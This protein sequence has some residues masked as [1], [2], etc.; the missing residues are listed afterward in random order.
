MSQSRVLGCGLG[1]GLGC[2]LG[3]VLG[4]LGLGL[5]FRI[6]TVRNLGKSIMPFPCAYTPSITSLSFSSFVSRPCERRTVSS[7]E[8]VTL[9]LP[10]APS[11]RSCIIYHARKMRTLL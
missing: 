1:G 6:I 8:V 11:W 2:V 10:P 5:G 4:G 3:C 9:P 7:S